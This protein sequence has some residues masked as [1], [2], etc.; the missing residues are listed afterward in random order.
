MDVTVTHWEKKKTQVQVALRFTHSPSRW[1]LRKGF[2]VVAFVFWDA[3]GNEL[4]ASCSLI[5]LE[6]S[7][8]V[9][10]KGIALGEFTIAI[11]EGARTMRA[12]IGYS[13]MMTTPIVVPIR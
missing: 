12:G 1:V 4:P 6:D 7:F 9:E 2:E 3:K 10:E 8:R 11:P 13:N 5:G